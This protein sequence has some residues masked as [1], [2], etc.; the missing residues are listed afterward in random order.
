MKMKDCPSCAATVPAVARLCKHCFHDFEAEVPKKSNS[1]TLIG[2]LAMLVLLGGIGTAMFSYLYENQAA[3]KMVV[4]AETQSLVLT[5]TSA[6]GTTTTRVNFADITKVEYV[7]SPGEFSVVAVDKND[8]RY[9]VQIS[10]KPIDGHAEHIANIIDTPMVEVNN[11][12][13]TSFAPSN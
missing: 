9:T 13:Q 12:P 2:F 3:E 6:R 10:G 7:K 11:L 4:D 5:R 1:N 8:D